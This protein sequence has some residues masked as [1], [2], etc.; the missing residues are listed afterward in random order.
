MW[1]FVDHCLSFYPFSF[2]Y[3]VVCPS[4][5]GYLLPLSYFQALPCLCP[6]FVVIPYLALFPDCV[7]LYRI[8]FCI[9]IV[10]CCTVSCFVSR[11]CCVVPYLVLY[12]DCVVLYRIL[13]CIQIVLCYTVS[14]FV[15]R[16]CCVIPYLVL[17]PYC[18]VLYRILFCIQIVLCYTYL[19]LYPDCV[20]PYL[21]LY[22]DFVV[23]QYYEKKV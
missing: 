17:Y 8:V 18:V 19:V 21:G 5:Y 22:L 11:L 20:E 9:Q 23:A 14:C 6:D 16:L 10:L 2:G 3:C 15:S 13:V 7:V 4:I 12:P 1:C